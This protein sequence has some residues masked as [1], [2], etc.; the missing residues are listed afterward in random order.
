M[1]GNTVSFTTPDTT[2]VSTTNIYHPAA[3]CRLDTYFA[4]ALCTIMPD[5]DVIP[6]LTA[7]M[8]K[9]SMQAELGQAV[10]SCMT[11]SPLVGAVGYNGK[12]RPRCWFKQQLDGPF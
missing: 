10:Y 9:N 12:N 7:P 5:L 3:Q 4:G 8:G 1:E 11:T 6:G 2:Q